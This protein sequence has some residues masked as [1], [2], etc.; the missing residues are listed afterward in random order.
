MSLSENRVAIVAGTR[1][2]FVK[3]GTAFSAY[4]M[5]ELGEHVLKSLLEKSGV[6]PLVVEE[7]IFFC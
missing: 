4:T 5:Q 6:N 7:F 3:M 1:T 2:P